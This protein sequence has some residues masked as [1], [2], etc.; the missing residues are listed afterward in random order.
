[1]TLSELVH[2]N[3]PRNIPVRQRHAFGRSLNHFQEE[4]N[5]LFQDFFGNSALSR[6]EENFEQMPAIDVVENDKDFKI[7]AELAGMDPE[8]VDVSVTDGYLTIKGE[9]KE[10][11]EEKDDNYLRQEMSYGSFRRSI[12][13]PETANFDKADA[14][15]KNGILTIQIPKKSGAVQK[16]KKLQIKK[17]A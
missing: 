14:S 13:L 2:W 8:N 5:H 16:P 17:A 7:K 15:F 6:F 10:E 12:S 4:M 9:R 3:R 1:M 11:K